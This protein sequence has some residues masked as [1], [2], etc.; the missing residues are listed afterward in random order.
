[1]L[2]RIHAEQLHIMT[3][4]PP[5]NDFDYIDCEVPAEQTLTEWRRER[6]AVERAER[7]PRRLCRMARERWA[8]W[9]A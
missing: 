3:T 1:M 2:R 5:S 4:T 7:R 6:A 8:R 9:T